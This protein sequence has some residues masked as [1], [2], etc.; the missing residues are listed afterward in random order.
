MIVQHSVLAF[1]WIFYCVAHSLLAAP[2][3]KLFFEKY[4][5]KYF[6]YYRLA[7][8]LFASF[9]LLLLLYYQYSIKTW[10]LF[11]SGIV[12]RLAL[13]LLVIPGLV[14][15]LASIYK[16]FRLLSGIRTLYEAKPPAELK[17]NGM[18]TY[19]R[20]P[21]YSG[22]LLFI[23]GL[24]FIFPLLGNLIS[25]VIITLYVLVG[26]KYEERKLINEFGDTY[27]NYC[28]EVPKF[29]PRI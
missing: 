17:V 19:V 26:I 12:V 15:M 27:K 21:L 8:S 29:I 28:L 6:R 1:S 20:H 7:Y 14:I 3:C 2:A 18:H 11:Y 16:Y 4:T 9:T 10:R 5:G 13:F 23:W 22:T 25:V 24:F